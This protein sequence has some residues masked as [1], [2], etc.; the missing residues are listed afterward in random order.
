MILS[1]YAPVAPSKDRDRKSMTHPRNIVVPPFSA[2][3]A[4]T[5]FP[6]NINSAMPTTMIHTFRYLFSGYFLPRN[7][8][9][10]MTGIGLQDLAKT[11]TGKITYRNDLTEKKVE[12]MLS[13]ATTNNLYVGTVVGR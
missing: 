12:P 9:M 7:A 1:S 8:P 10:I 11:C 13:M 6:P 3:S 4:L 5:A 2:S